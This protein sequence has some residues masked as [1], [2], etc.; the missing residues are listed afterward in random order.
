MLEFQRILLERRQRTLCK[1]ERT[2]S[3]DFLIGCSGGS[4][5][6]DWRNDQGKYD[7]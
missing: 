7:V 5:D 2:Y 1:V 4:Y 3:S 6:A